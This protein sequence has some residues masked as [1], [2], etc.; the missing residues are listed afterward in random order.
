LEIADPLDRLAQLAAEL[1]LA[2]KLIAGYPVPAD[3]PAIHM[4][5]RTEL[6]A[7]VCKGTCTE[8]KCFYRPDEGVFVDAALDFEHDVAA[9][10]VLLHELVHHVQALSGKFDRIASRCDRWY[11]KEV[12]AYEIQNAYM[13]LND[14]RRRYLFDALPMT[15]NDEEANRP[16]ID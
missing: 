13:R 2:I 1:F 9:R 14:Q 15:C 4:L 12:E 3:P 8:L 10:S 5:T 11:L 7:A 16:S 6:A